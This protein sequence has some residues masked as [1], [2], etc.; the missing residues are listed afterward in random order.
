MTNQRIRNAMYRAHLKQWQLANLLHISEFTLCRRMR[1]EMS[2]E[3][4]D[5]IV[6]I[7]EG[8][9]DSQRDE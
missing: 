2:A 9:E 8:K 1:L 6:A 7:I 3:E 5:R 4:Q